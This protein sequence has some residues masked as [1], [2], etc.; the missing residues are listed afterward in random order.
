MCNKN[1]VKDCV[2]IGAGPAGSTA[3]IYLARFR[4]DIV[5]FDNHDSR[6]NLIPLSHNLP[7][8]P[9]GISGNEV[10]KQAHQQLGKYDVPIL[11]NTVKVIHKEDNIF[12][13]CTKDYSVRAKKVLLATGVTDIE[14]NLPNVEYAIRRGLIR[15]CPV[16]DAYEVINQ[17]VAVIGHGKQGLGEAFFMR[18]YTSHIT[19]LTL[20]Q[21]LQLTKEEQEKIQALNIRIIYEPIQTVTI[22]DNKITALNFSANKNYRFDTIYSALGAEI[23]SDLAVKLGAKHLPNKCLRV[24]EH[25]QTSVPGLYAAGDIVASLNQIS[26]AMG[27]AAIAATAI[28][29]SL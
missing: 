11:N 19:L 5:V 24:D 25:Q 17:D 10:L 22:I 20:G 6:A 14:P 13:V 29:R 7:W 8:A 28:H 16:C 18:H 2:I 27:Q 23:R 4:R 12:S 1:L 15:H 26:V 3:A 9:D 21:D